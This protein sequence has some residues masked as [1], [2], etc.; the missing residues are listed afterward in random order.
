MYYLCVHA[1]PLPRMKN[2]GHSVDHWGYTTSD[3]PTDKHYATVYTPLGPFTHFSVYLTAQLSNSCFFILL[4]VSQVLP[5]Q[6]QVQRND[7]VPVPADYAIFVT[8]Q[9]AV[10]LLGHLGTLLTL[11]Q[12]AVD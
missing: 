7:H 1:A 11:I 9:D 4:R 5:H 10:D 6:C 2:I 8:S 3:W 12:Q